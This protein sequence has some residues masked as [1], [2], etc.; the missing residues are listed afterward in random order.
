[1]TM[2]LLL[3]NYALFN[4]PTLLIVGWLIAGLEAITAIL[5]FIRAVFRNNKK[6]VERIDKSI[7]KCEKTLTALRR[8]QSEYRAVL[9]YEAVERGE[10]NISLTDNEKTKISEAEQNGANDK[11]NNEFPPDALITPADGVEETQPEEP[12]EADEEPEPAR[13]DAAHVELAGESA[14]LLAKFIGSLKKND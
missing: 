13:E 14:E 12:Q 2:T 10:L 7:A 11:N 1:M 8:K 3:F 9:A 5:H 6:I 4:D